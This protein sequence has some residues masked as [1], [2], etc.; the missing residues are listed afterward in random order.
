[1]DRRAAGVIPRIFWVFSTGRVLPYVARPRFGVIF[2]C[3]RGYTFRARKMTR[4]RSAADLNL[5]MCA[6]SPLASGLPGVVIIGKTVLR[7]RPNPLGTSAAKQILVIDGDPEIREL[8]AATVI[9]AG[10]LADIEGDG[11]NGWK[12]LCRVAYDLVITGDELPGL[13]GVELI[14]RIRG[15]SKEP[16]CMLILSQQLEGKSIPMPFIVADGLLAKP[17]TPVALIERVYEL[18]LRGHSLEP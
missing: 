10:F 12:A 17:F 5:R 1:M 2:E 9:R 7:D 18:L 3:R 16:P 6:S 14:E 11:E 4:N 15:F 13:T 8:V